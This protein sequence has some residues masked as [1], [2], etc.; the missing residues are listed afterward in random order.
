MPRGNVKWLCALFMMD[1][2]E[3][4]GN[5]S[6]INLCQF[7]YA[8]TSGSKIGAS[9][10]MRHLGYEQSLQ[11]LDP[12]SSPFFTWWKAWPAHLQTA[13]FSHPKS[14]YLAVR[15]KVRL[16]G[17]QILTHKKIPCCCQVNY[18]SGGMCHF[19]CPSE[20]SFCS[21]HGVVKH[22]IPSLWKSSLVSQWQA[23]TLELPGSF[24]AGQLG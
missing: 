1:T 24:L 21:W 4:K 20:W 3:P 13:H 10:L 18:L 23:D 6:I 14:C 8:T 11:C 17:L 5:F 12:G 19:F 15:G 9:N 2:R 7:L 22:R 16:S